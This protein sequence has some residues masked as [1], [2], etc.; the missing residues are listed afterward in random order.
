VSANEFLRDEKSRGS[1]G[2][3]ASHAKFECAHVKLSADAVAR[4]LANPAAP[5]AADATTAP[6]VWSEPNRAVERL[7]YISTVFSATTAA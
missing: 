5:A 1:A 2:E 6:L 3:D 7:P 4:V